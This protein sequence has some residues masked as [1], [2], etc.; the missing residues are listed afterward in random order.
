MIGIID[1]FIRV[2]SSS[3]EETAIGKQQFSAL[4]VY[5]FTMIIGMGATALGFMGPQ[6]FY[7]Y[8]LNSVYVTAAIVMYL[9][10]IF[11]KATVSLSF[12]VII[13]LTQIFTS[14]EMLLCA[15]YPS[16]YS[17]KLI[18]ADV[19]ILA[20]NILFSLIAYLKYVPPLL[21]ASGIAVVWACVV[22]TAD[23]SM[24]NFA[25]L[26]T[27]IFVNTA[28]LS[29]KLLVNLRQIK[30]ENDDLKAEEKELLSVLKL[31]RNGVKAFTELAK[32][33][34]AYKDTALYL[35]IM[36]VV[37]K[38]NLIENV[39]EYLRERDNQVLD[40]KMLF[41]ELTHSEQEICSLIVQGK[42]QGEIC[43]ILNKKESNIT[44]QRS[45]I[46]RKLGLAPADDLR[47]ALLQ[48]VA[49]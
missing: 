42:K 28:I 9:L 18:I 36:G 16:A 27:L 12:G 7:P 35:D 22:I 32:H 19:V 29:N 44:A 46:R 41:P 38:Q 13:L 21:A 20:V 3:R 25:V 14:L 31:K 48:R 15:Y 6:G 23:E 4:S 43:I 5:V 10:Y 34:Y 39:K 47:E 26:F 30:A 17:L 2:F 37:A 8:L 45:N 24:Q 1:S 49:R 33:E 11:R 40:F